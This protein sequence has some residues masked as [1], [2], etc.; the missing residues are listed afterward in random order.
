MR[1]TVKIGVLFTSICFVVSASGC[2]KKFDPNAFDAGASVVASASAAA[3][4]TPPIDSSAATDTGDA[5]DS[6]AP[7][8]EG[9]THTAPTGAT[10][11]KGDPS[12][13]VQAREWCN[14]KPPAERHS[15]EGQKNCNDFRFAC[16]NKGGHL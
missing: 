14:T 9:K 4:A 15:K 12:E 3:S 1:N 11:P 5:G 7:L 10:K 8:V 6:L 2:K 16:F 13:C